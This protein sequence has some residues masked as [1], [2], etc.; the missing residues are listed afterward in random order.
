M[1]RIATMLLIVCTSGV[2]LA[3]STATV[4]LKAV[5]IP[6]FLAHQEQLRDDLAGAKFAHLDNQSKD[7][8]RAAQDA[9]FEVLAGKRTVDELDDGERRRVFDAQNEIAA[10][11]DDAEADR[12][13]CA[14]APRLGSRLHNVECW[15]K[16]E[17]ELE[18]SNRNL[19]LLRNQP[20][21]DSQNCNVSNADVRPGYVNYRERH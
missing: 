17:R 1:L 14:N 10:V 7:R 6:A 5:D 20:C 19:E 16:R 4:P 18:R 9:L 8:I 13:I 21:G 11:L 3:A 12:P 15:S 2:A